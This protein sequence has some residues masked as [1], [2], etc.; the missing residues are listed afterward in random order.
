[1]CSVTD[2]ERSEAS[3]FSWTVT[4]NQAEIACLGVVVPMP[5]LFSGNQDMEISIL[6][7]RSQYGVLTAVIR[8]HLIQ[9]GTPTV[10]IECDAPMDD[11]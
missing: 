6:P 4:G 5:P 8:R 1:M 3:A 9:M 11:C 7:V 2:A 10:I